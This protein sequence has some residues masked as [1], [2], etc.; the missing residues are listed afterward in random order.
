MLTV[1]ELVSKLNE[2]EDQT[3]P[4]M[5]GGV[6]GEIQVFMAGH[7]EDG[8]TALILT[9]PVLPLPAWTRRGAGSGQPG[10]EREIRRM[11]EAKG[12]TEPRQY[13]WEGRR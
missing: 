7:T 6:G 4:V 8:G 10:S 13:K 3:M 11:V 5:I 12:G 9:A 2:V 1:G